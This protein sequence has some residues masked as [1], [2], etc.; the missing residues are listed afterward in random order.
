VTYKAG[1]VSEADDITRVALGIA[2]LLR[3]SRGGVVLG[4]RGNRED[5]GEEDL[6]EEHFGVKRYYTITVKLGRRESEKN[7]K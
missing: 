2:L 1:A 6:V 3:V 4:A 7:Q 5:G